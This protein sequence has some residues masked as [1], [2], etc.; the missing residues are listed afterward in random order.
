MDQYVQKIQKKLSTVKLK[1]KMHFLK[2]IVPLET[3]LMLN[4]VLLLNFIEYTF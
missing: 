1:T 2:L 3:I 4:N